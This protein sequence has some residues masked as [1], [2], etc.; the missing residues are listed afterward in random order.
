MVEDLSTEY[1]DVKT[2][3][4]VLSSPV[5][6]FQWPKNDDCC[7]VPVHHILCSI[8]TPV[9]TTGIIYTITNEENYKINDL[10]AKV[11]I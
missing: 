3:F 8:D 7:R 4:M 2:K 6:S 1:Q 10:H 9:T 5:V 11:T